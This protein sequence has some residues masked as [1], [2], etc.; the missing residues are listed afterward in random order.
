VMCKS[1]SVYNDLFLSFADFIPTIKRTSL[2]ENVPIVFHN[3]CRLDS[4]GH[5]FMSFLEN[6]KLQTYRIV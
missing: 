1:K 5:L 3:H 6:S 4:R 2:G